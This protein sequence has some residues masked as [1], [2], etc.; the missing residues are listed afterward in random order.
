MGDHHYFLV[1]PQSVRQGAFTL[2]QAE[3][4]HLRQVLRLQTGAEIWLT[5]GQGMMY[6]AIVERFAG[7]VAQGR[8]TGI[9]PAA[10]ELSLPIELAAGLIRREKFELL[11]EKAVELGIAAIRPLILDRCIKRSLNQERIRKLIIAAAKQCG[12]SRVATLHEPQPF[13]NWLAETADNVRLICHP[14][15]DRTISDW[16]AA[17]GLT[18]GRIMVLIGPEGDFSERELTTAIAGGCIPVTLG[19]RRL[20]SETAALTAL[21]ILSEC[22]QRKGIGN[23]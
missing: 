11:V 9:F 14:S 3:T 12:R 19:D 1:D 21:A 13:E 17:D 22:I 2:D 18:A 15:G 10:G 23:E 4:R 16:F 7:S 5:D 8:I 6:S 20:R